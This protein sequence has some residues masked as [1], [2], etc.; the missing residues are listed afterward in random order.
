MSEVMNV[1][2]LSSGYQENDPLWCPQS[3]V[4][5][6]H[7]LFFPSIYGWASLFEVMGVNHNIQG[8]LGTLSKSD[9]R[10]V[11]EGEPV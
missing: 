4:S 7:R 6:N 3:V 5:Q 8:L 11:L 10:M 2:M 9:C 1:Q